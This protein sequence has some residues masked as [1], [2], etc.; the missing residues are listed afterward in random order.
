LKRQPFPVPYGL[1]IVLAVYALL[2]LGYVWATYWN[3]PEYLAAEHYAQASDLLGLDDGKTASKEILL[4]AYNH[5][6]EAA[7][8]VPRAL[9]LHKRVEAMRWRLDER[10][11]KLDHDMQMRAEAVSMLWQ[12]IQ[13]E[14][15]PILVVGARDRGWQPAQLL[16]GPGRSF[17]Y[18]L[19]GGLVI[20]LIW[21]WTRFSGRRVREQDREKELKQIE[22]DNAAIAAERVRGSKAGLKKQRSKNR[23]P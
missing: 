4:S 23:S 13:Q 11:F 1:F 22:A 18:A 2:V 5:Y 21:G 12:R 10:G 16:E 8:L 3:S 15:D 20:I 14:Q 6:L 17:L 9:V 7:R 19:P